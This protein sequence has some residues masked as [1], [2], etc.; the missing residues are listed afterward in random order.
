MPWVEAKLDGR[1]LSLHEDAQHKAE[2]TKLDGCY[3]LKTNLTATQASKETVHRRYKDLAQVEWA[4]RSAKSV[5]QMRPI[6]VRLATRTRG[7]ALVVMLAYRIIQELAKRWAGLNLTVAEG[8]AQLGTLCVHDL[9][10]DGRNVTRC[11]PTPNAQV[12]ALFEHAK[13]NLPTAPSVEEPKISTKKNLAS[14]R[15]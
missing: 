10:V 2:H 12:M 3:V 1:V 9:C 5:L 15:N 14:R 13:I 8:V 7:H 11:V 4:F 6:Y